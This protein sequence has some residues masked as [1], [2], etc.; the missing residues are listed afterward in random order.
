MQQ[1]YACQAQFNRQGVARH[2]HN[3]GNF[4]SD[5]L[6]VCTQNGYE[7]TEWWFE[8]SG[9]RDVFHTYLAHLVVSAAD[10][11]VSVLEVREQK[12]KQKL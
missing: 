6:L 8:T 3:V 4:V 2:H 9:A 12:I 11:P 7:R 5:V 10:R 1:V